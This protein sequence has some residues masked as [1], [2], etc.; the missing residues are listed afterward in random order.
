MRECSIPLAARGSL[1]ANEPRTKTQMED[2][3]RS[4]Q[5]GAAGVNGDVRV[6]EGCVVSQWIRVLA[7]IVAMSV[8][9]NNRS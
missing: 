1:A 2:P 8:D 6:G 4:Q 7:R 3:A 5:D 9:V